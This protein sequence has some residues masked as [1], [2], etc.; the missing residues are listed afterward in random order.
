MIPVMAN[1]AGLFHGGA[2]LGAPRRVE[3]D[4]AKG[5]V[6]ARKLRGPI[7][8]ACTSGAVWLTREGGLDDVVLSAGTSYRGEVRGLVVVEALERAR[9]AVSSGGWSA[10]ARRALA[11]LR[12]NWLVLLSLFA[13][14]V[15]WGSTYLGMRIALETLPP[16][17]MAGVRFLIAGGLLY[18]ALRWRGEA[19]P[20]RKQWGASAIMGVLLCACGNGFLAIGQQQKWINSGVSSVVVTTMPLWVAVMSSG[21][22]WR[23]RRAGKE[24]ATVATS[25]G[26]WVGLVIGFA[27]AALLRLG[28][29]MQASGAGLL[30]VLLSPFCWA[31]GSVWSR[32]LP[33]PKGFMASATQMITGGLVMLAAGPLIGERIP[34]APSVRSLVALVYLT[35]FGSI[36]GFTAYSYLLRATRPAIATSYAYVNPVVAIALGIWFGGE[37]AKAT[38]WIAALVVITGVVILSVARARPTAAR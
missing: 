1:A 12:R 32:S 30:L 9:I 19:A 3:V 33:L 8:L 7:S 37:E 17:L 6:W 38:T 15:I 11:A 14:Y 22:A 2:A 26:E 28:G 24:T 5:A 18:G 25:T 36:V 10:G 16:F 21:S 35:V 20:D 27:G 4:L 34:E 23:A 29:T 13:L 31:L